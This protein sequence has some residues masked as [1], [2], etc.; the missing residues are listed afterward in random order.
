MVTIKS[1]WDQLPEAESSV[2]IRCDKS[3]VN[4]KVTLISLNEAL[5]DNFHLIEAYCNSRNM[6][7][8]YSAW[9]IDW[10]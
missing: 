1:A 7:R 2:A 8:L 3:W 9:I 6:M 4:V 10:P 5:Q